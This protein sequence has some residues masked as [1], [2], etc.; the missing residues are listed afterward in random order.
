MKQLILNRYKGKPKIIVLVDDEDF[1][2]LN[3]FSWAI[4]VL[5]YIVGEINNKRVYLHRIIMGTPKGMVTDHINGNKL[6]NRKSNL[7]ICLSKENSRNCKLSKNSITKISG[8]SWRW[9][10]NCYRAY[11]MVD[12]RQICLGHYK[13]IEKA[14]MARKEGEKKYFGEFARL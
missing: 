1:E 2:Y 5:G 4:S 8:V 9:Q 13:E 14:I 3:Q 11:I 12:R 6:D 7:R 10:R